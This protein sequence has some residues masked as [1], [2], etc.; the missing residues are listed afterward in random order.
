[1]KKVINIINI[2][3]L[4]LCLIHIF[5]SG[6]LLDGL[7]T[8][9]SFSLTFFR[10]CLTLIP[11][12][13]LGISFIGNII[14]LVFCI[15]RKK[16]KYLNI[17]SI[18]VIIMFVITFLFT[19]PF[20]FVHSEECNNS[21]LEDSDVCFKSYRYDKLFVYGRFE[22]EESGYIGDFGKYRYIYIPIAKKIIVFGNKIEKY[23]VKYLDSEQVKIGKKEYSIENYWYHE[24]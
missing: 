10:Y 23:D 21:K 5:F 24:S 16:K 19:T 2:C 1:M 12:L 13:L 6:S 4:C 18:L 11:Y 20:E 17:S 3:V 9:L 14:Y 15:S 22:S 7:L 8:N